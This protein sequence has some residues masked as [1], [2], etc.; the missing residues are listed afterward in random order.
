MGKIANVHVDRNGLVV[1][2][3][4]E[5]LRLLSGASVGR[6]AVTVG[7]LPV[8]LPVNFLRLDRDRVLIRTT[9]GT[10]LDAA[11]RHA[12]VAFEVDDFDSFSHT[13]WSVCVT[14]VAARSRIATTSTTSTG[15]RSPIGHRMRRPRHR[16]VDRDRHRPSHRIAVRAFGAQPVG[17]GTRHSTTVPP[18]PG[19]DRELPPWRS[20]R[21]RMFSRPRPARSRSDEIPIPSSL[22]VNTASRSTVMST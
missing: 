15:S 2:G 11:T 21:V 9:T 13:G 4:T 10:K 18:S 16:D 7:A 17:H 22:T 19:R 6:L 8:I 20:A 3:R 14:G 5:C 1:L 12:V